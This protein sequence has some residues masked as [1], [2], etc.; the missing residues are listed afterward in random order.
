MTALD[1][2]FQVVRAAPVGCS[3]CN[4]T[5]MA[6]LPDGLVPLNFFEPRGDREEQMNASSGFAVHNLGEDGQ[7]K[8]ALDEIPIERP[9]VPA[10]DGNRSFSSPP[11]GWP[12]MTPNRSCRSTGCGAWS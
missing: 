2:D 8:H 1:H 4:G 12:S 6:V 10:E 3:E 11:A 7:P 5:D 9:F